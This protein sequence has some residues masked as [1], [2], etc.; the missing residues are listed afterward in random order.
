LFFFL[1]VQVGMVLTF[2]RRKELIA[3]HE[4]AVAEKLAKK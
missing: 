2:F 3:Q 1:L 4:K